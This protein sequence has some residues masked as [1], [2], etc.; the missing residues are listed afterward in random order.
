MLVS[1]ESHILHQGSNQPARG[2]RIRNLKGFL[3]PKERALEMSMPV[4]GR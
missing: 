2:L 4:P 3:S 1:N